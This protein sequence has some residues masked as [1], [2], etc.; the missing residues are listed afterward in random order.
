VFRGVVRRPLV[1]LL[2]SAVALSLGTACYRQV[3]VETAALAPDATVRVF[4]SPSGEA[5]LAPKLGAE[6]IAVD[7]RVERVDAAGIALVVSRTTKRLGGTV[8]WIGER[9]TIPTTSIARTEH[10]AL[11]RHRTIFFAAAGGIAAAAAIAVLIAQAGGG[12]GTEPPGGVIS[13]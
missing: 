9:V 4:L 3:P 7:G 10:R 6:T 1:S 11:D 2:P 13:P 5:E 8:P 12:S